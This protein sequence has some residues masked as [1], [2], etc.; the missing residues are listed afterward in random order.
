MRIAILTIPIV[1][2]ACAAAPA[3]KSPQPQSPPIGM[4]NPASRYCADIGGRSEIRSEPQGQTGYCH[5]PD[6]R[7]VEEWQLFREA[8][9]DND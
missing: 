9:K 4:A 5:L 3:E 6:G 8:H 2:S 7:V 1:L